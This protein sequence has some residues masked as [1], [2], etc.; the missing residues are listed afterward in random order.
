V[1]AVTAI[2]LVVFS[3]EVRDIE[4]MPER[5]AEQSG[6]QVEAIDD[7]RVVCLFVGEMADRDA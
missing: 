5:F 1:V 2:L 6:F 4:Q 3:R 7:R